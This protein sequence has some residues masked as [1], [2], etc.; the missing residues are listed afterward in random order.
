M[1]NGK[2]VLIGIATVGNVLTANLT[3]PDGLF[4]GRDGLFA[5]NT[6]GETQYSFDVCGHPELCKPFNRSNTLLLTDAYAGK[7]IC[8]TATY[9]D[10]SHNVE[11]V[12][13]NAV[14]VAA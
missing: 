5:G 13:S 3:D 7:K 10:M 14:T 8:A 9:Q 4:D 12:V 2:L 1:N 6:M 11:Y